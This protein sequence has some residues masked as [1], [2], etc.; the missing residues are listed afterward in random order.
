MVEHIHYKMLRNLI[1]H[2]S[3]L[4]SRLHSS[5]NK[6]IASLFGMSSAIRAARQQHPLSM[7]AGSTLLQRRTVEMLVR[8][9]TE[10]DMSGSSKASQFWDADAPFASASLVEMQKSPGL[11]G[12][13]VQYISRW[14]QSPIIYPLVH[15]VQYKGRLTKI[16]ILILEVILKKKIPM[17]VV[18]MSR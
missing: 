16:L 9:C 8:R 17:T 18:T 11:E 5:I 6:R 1:L 4:I 10:P 7:N 3:Y 15:S 12:P 2:I 14:S 13:V